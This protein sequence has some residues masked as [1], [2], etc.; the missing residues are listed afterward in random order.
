M[1]AARRRNAGFSLLETLAMLVVV[2]FLIA[3]LAAGTN[4]GLRSWST[5]TRWSRDG[6]EADGVVRILRGL[7]V[8]MNGGDVFAGPLPVAGRAHALSFVTELPA[9]PA[10]ER[11][12]EASVAIGVEQGDLVLHWTPHLPGRFG[13]AATRTE[14]LAPAVASVE[15]SYWRQGRWQD[16]WT[17]DGVPS[18]VRVRILRKPG[19]PGV[20]LPDI[21]AGPFRALLAPPS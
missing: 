20:D 13:P 12:A 17:G 3:G 6:F 4:V 9:L 2:G 16:R 11:T 8:G 1:S 10:G 7:I 14:L 21:V 19:S 5:E 18:L 15:F